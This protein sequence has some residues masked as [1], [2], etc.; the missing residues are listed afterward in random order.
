MIKGRLKLDIF[1]NNVKIGGF[2]DS[3]LVTLS[4]KQLIAFLMTGE[5]G[6]NV[7]TKV[8]I[9]DGTSYPVTTDV[10]LSNIFIKAVAGHTLLEQS[11]VQWHFTID[12]E[13]AN[14]MN[15]SEFGLFSQDERLF[16]RKIRV[17]SIPKDDSIRLAGYWT[18][19]LRECKKTTFS[20]SAY[21]DFNIT[22]PIFDGGA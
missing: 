3:N 21:I 5:P 9:G 17:P 8:G 7:I 19:W 13:E 11:V 15:I 12:D 18:I 10:G 6:E 2:E 4:G 14:G 16:A 20:S 22:D 1:K